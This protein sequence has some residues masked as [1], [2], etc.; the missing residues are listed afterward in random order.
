LSYCLSKI[1]PGYTTEWVCLKECEVFTQLPVEYTKCLI[2]SFPS[3]SSYTSPLS[4]HAQS[5]ATSS[6]V[7]SLQ[8]LQPLGGF[9]HVESFL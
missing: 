2:S 8:W 6:S 5:R 4:C 1:L 3:R 7:Q 9:Q